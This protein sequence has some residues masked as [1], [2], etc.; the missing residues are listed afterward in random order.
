MSSEIS[1][2]ERQR[3]AKMARNKLAM[4]SIGLLDAKD[5]LKRKRE[6]ERE[7]REAA[8]KRQK[9]EARASF[10]PRRTSRDTKPIT[11]IKDEWE[12]PSAKQLARLAELKKMALPVTGRLRDPCLLC[13]LHV[14][15]PAM[16]NHIGAHI[17]AE[18]FAVIRCGTCGL[19]SSTCKFKREQGYN[20]IVPVGDDV[21]PR[22]H[23]VNLK[24]AA[25][26][27]CTNLP[28]R[29]TKCREWFW[30][31]TMKQ[32]LNDAHGGLK[33]LSKRDLAAC[34]VSNDEERTMFEEMAR[35]NERLLDDDNDSDLSSG[36]SD[37]DDGGRGRRRG[38]VSV[39]RSYALRERKPLA[40]IDTD[41]N[42]F[43][44]EPDSDYD[45]E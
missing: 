41:D 30:T 39:V 44:S 35:V 13:G 22:Y 8:R 45:D 10:V 6:E 15:R 31:Y 36:S 3:Q 20:F 18:K 32:H 42:E 12:A 16:R 21:C 24:T 17:V 29:C 4:A 38:A 37:D 1:E 14:D 19:E 40:E 25:N 34:A 2:Y 7:A 23:K 43:S 11:Y 27:K 26:G 33:G 28:L 9:D 5:E